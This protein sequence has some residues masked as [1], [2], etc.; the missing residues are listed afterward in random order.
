MQKRDPKSI[1]CSPYL[2]LIWQTAHSSHHKEHNLQH[3]S[4]SSEEKNMPPKSANPLPVAEIKK[5]KQVLKA[6]AGEPGIEELGKNT[7][8]APV[9]TRGPF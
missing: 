1:Y 4:H 7:V 3:L 8:K 5:L 9:R 2:N 6:R